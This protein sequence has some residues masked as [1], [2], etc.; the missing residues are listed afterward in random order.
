[1]DA[2]GAIKNLLPD[3]AGLAEVRE[4]TWWRG[5]KNLRPLAVEIWDGGEGM[6]TPPESGAPARAALRYLENRLEQPDSTQAMS[7]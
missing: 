3:D 2:C 5:T 1:M 7:R 4:Q 6:R